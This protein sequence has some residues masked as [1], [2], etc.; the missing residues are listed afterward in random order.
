M[1]RKTFALGL[2]AIGLGTGIAS[3]QVTVY[4]SD[5]PTARVSFADLDVTSPAGIHRLQNRVRSAAKALCFDN[6]IDPVWMTM[7]HN[8]CYDAAL[9]DGFAQIDRI[10]TDKLARG[11][12]ASGAIQL[13]AR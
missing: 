8:R 10:A 6:S 4:G 5:V 2:I 11:G 1:Y 7:S 3:A 12:R 13:S 9:S